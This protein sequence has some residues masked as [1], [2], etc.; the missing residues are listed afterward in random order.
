MRL[1]LYKYLTY[2]VNR[3]T[4][5]C[6]NCFTLAPPNSLV[7]FP[8]PS[9]VTTLTWLFRCSMTA[10]RV[11]F[12]QVYY[13]R[14]YTALTFLD[15]PLLNKAG[16]IL[17]AQGGMHLAK[18]SKSDVMIH[19][20]TSRPIQQFVRFVFPSS[21]FLINQLCSQMLNWCIHR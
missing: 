1:V 18:V 10:F 2:I 15:F 13:V 9:F 4:G 17:D 8:H 19:K 3:P 16:K 12:T 6:P 11:I 14:N 5:H 21:P 20:L 7:F